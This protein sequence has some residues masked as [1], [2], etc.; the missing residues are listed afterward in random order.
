M[1]IDVAL[2]RWM[3]AREVHARTFEVVPTEVYDAITDLLVDK[4]TVFPT[5]RRFFE[6]NSDPMPCMSSWNWS[7]IGQSGGTREKCRCRCGNGSLTT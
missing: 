6:L 3:L 4:E 2:K 5:I 1:D 7:T